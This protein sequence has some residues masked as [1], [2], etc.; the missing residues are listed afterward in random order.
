MPDKTTYTIREKD[1]N[2][3]RPEITGTGEVVG[4]GET[5]GEINW[6]DDKYQDVSYVNVYCY[7]LPETGG[8]GPIIYTMAGVLAIIFGAGFMYRKKVRERRV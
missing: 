7:E 1:Y 2:G 3:Y 6:D 4:G 8:S 5:N